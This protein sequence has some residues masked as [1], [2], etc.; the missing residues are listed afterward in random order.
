M[1]TIIP[2]AF[3]VVLFVAAVG[4][5][6]ASRGTKNKLV[7]AAE[8]KEIKKSNVKRGSGPAPAVPDKR[9]VHKPTSN[10]AHRFASA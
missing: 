10:I 6:V 8:I 7:V 3:W 2:H 1:S 5:T 9:P 4:L